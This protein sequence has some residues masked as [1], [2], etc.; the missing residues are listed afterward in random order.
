M[1]NGTWNGTLLEA[2]NPSVGAIAIDTIA[3]QPFAQALRWSCRDLVNAASLPVTAGTQVNVTAWLD[4]SDL[5]GHPTDSDPWTVGIGMRFTTAAG[6]VSWVS[7]A[8]IPSGSG[9]TLVSGQITVPPLAVS[10]SPWLQL[11]ATIGLIGSYY[12]RAAAIAFTTSFNGWNIIAL[13]PRP[14][15]RQIDFSISDSVGEN[16]SPFTRQSQVQLWPGADWWSLNVSMPA[17]K[18]PWA[19]NWIAWLAALQGKFNA[20]QIGDPSGIAPLGTPMGSPVCD[21]SYPGYNLTTANV[22][23]T[24]GWT[25]NKYRLLLPGDYLQIGYRLHFVTY[26]CAA[27]NSDANGNAAIPVWPSIREL[28]ADGQPI[29]LHNTSG[30]FRLETNTRNWTANYLKVIPVGFKCKEAR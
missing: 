20:F 11:N 8:T 5:T 18:R 24:R 13:P 1:I 7:I 19:N 3:A 26:A 28:P 9:W 2:W 6:V 10:M 17:M 4:A 16:V 29:L 14:V 25:P 23:H 15:P 21:C 22:L 30:L 12:A 27:V